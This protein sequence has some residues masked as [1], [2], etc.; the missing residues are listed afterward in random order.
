MQG[1]CLCT[2]HFSLTPL[3][4]RRLEKYQRY[5]ATSLRYLS[6]FVET[7]VLLILMEQ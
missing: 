4:C 3:I 5:Q 7:F 6:K 2:L 1:L